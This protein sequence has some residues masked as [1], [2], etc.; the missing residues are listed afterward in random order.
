[1]TG[2]ADG[3]GGGGGFA[4]R[5][6]KLGDPAAWPDAPR[7]VD[8]AETHLSVVF[9]TDTRAYKLKKPVRT[10][11]VDLR[12]VEDRRA[13]CETEIRLNRR[14]APEIYLRTVA[15][16]RVG[17]RLVIDPS[18]T[19]G[20]VEDWLIE[21]VRLPAELM[22]D[23][24]IA[25]GDVAIGP[26][27]AA[28][29]RFARFAAALPA[30]ALS[31]PAYCRRLADGI[32]RAAAVLVD[33]RSGLDRVRIGRLRDRLT[34]VLTRHADRFEDR[35]AAGRIVEGHGDLRPEHVCL[36]DPPG[37]IDCLE[38]S[39][40]LRIQ[41]S[42]AE[43]CLLDLECT[44]LGDARI[45]RQMRAAYLEAAGDAAPTPLV[46]FHLAE[47]A[48]IRAQLAIWHRSEP[49]TGRTAADWTARAV[50]YLDLA[51]AALEA[52]GP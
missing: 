47:Q 49:G 33:P 20:P 9:L 32:G 12:R 52:G 1:M 21:M 46:G 5:V 44:R 39:R 27:L 17:H 35:A 10:G 16:C 43:L 37:I 50:H 29:E 45:G 40:D 18:A 24:R 48:L 51:E 22:L 42:L 14:I 2:H 13:H 36:V 28:A 11:F 30:E 41:D 34:D 6:A 15:A 19:A 23:A 25:T 8:Q 7:R 4:E 26:A 38:F 31:G 3:D